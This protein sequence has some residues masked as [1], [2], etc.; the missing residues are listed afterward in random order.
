[1]HLCLLPAHTA[2]VCP[3]APCYF[4]ATPGSGKLR[5]PTPHSHSSLQA[6]AFPR[7]EGRGGGKDALGLCSPIFHP[8]L[9]PPQ[10]EEVFPHLPGKTH[11]PQTF[12]LRI[13][14]AIHQIL[15]SPLRA[16][17]TQNATQRSFSSLFC[18]LSCHIIPLP[19]GNETRACCPRHGGEDREYQET[20]HFSI[21][22]V[23]HVTS[24]GPGGVKSLCHFPATNSEGKRHWWKLLY[25]GTS[26]LDPFLPDWSLNVHFPL[27][28]L[29]PYGSTCKGLIWQSWWSRFHLRTEDLVFSEENPQLGK[30]VYRWFLVF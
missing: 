3:A 13:T 22:C 21:T 9:L 24:A 28:H 18:F 15:S 23:S 1:M 10:W 8:S 27:L 4:G 11:S 5:R 14:L 12:F 20:N 26:T 25:L 16:F 2:H 7:K 29:V 30:P 6:C 17:I 19:W